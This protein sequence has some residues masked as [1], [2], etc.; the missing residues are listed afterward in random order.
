MHF[1]LKNIEGFGVLFPATYVRTRINIDFQSKIAYQ[2]LYY[3]VSLLTRVEKCSHLGLYEINLNMEKFDH[4]LLFLVLKTNHVNCPFALYYKRYFHLH[5]SCTISGML[6]MRDCAGNG[7]LCS[8]MYQNPLFK[9]E[10][11]IASSL[12]ISWVPFMVYVLAWLS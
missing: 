8:Y 7:R 2:V 12:I 6:V 4:T 9:Y 10:S 3:E 5:L 11:S 1:W